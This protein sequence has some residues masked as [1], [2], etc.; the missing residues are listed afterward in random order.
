MRDFDERFRSLRAVRAPDLWPDIEARRPTQDRPPRAARWAAAAAALAVAVAGLLVASRAFRSEPLEPR[1][2]SV[3]PDPVVVG[4]IEIPGANAVVAGE[5]SVWVAAI[6][7]DGGCDG[8]IHRIDPV[9][10]EAIAR[11]SIDGIVN[12]EVGGGGMDV[13]PGA[14]WVTGTVCGPGGDGAV[15][16][17]IDPATNEVTLVAPLG[18]GFGA[19]VATTEDAVWVTVFGERTDA[20]LLRVDPETGAI[21]ATVP[22]GTPY[23]REV[24]AAYGSIWVHPRIVE[25]STVGNGFLVK[26]DPR[27]NEIV[28]TLETNME[29]PAAW[30]G[31]LW[32]HHGDALLRIDPGR[33]GISERHPDVGYGAYWLLR[34]GAGG[35]WFLRM[36]DTP[37]EGGSPVVRYNPESE[38]IDVVVD[39]GP[40]VIPID[41]A[42]TDSSVW[43]VN[44]EGSVTRIDLRSP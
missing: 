2:A 28:G 32:A 3:P 23:A 26:V 34:S 9:S 20:K 29:A 41:L 38:R 8:T 10:G 42:I 21:E 18:P 30:E 27:T 7:T 12:W 19:D 36:D 6:S 16:Q 44:Y 37:G 39:L 4:T 14:L 13:R 5:G 22:L 35:L 25:A 17:R 1:P 40:D 43:T 15:L 24:L 31:S 33:V 11:I